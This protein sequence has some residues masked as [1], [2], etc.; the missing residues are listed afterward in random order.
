[1]AG[2]DLWR[3]EAISEEQI[4]GFLLRPTALATVRICALRVALAKPVTALRDE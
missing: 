3:E 4:F 1:M 2:K